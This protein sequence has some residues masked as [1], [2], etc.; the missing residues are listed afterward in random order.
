WHLHILWPEARLSKE[1]F[2]LLL[3]SLLDGGLLGSGLGDVSPSIARV[4][5]AGSGGE[6]SGV[7]GGCFGGQASP[8]ALTKDMPNGSGRNGGHGGWW[9]TAEVVKMMAKEL[10]RRR[11]IRS[12]SA[13]QPNRAKTFQGLNKIIYAVP[14][15]ANTDQPAL[16]L[17]RPKPPNLVIRI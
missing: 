16:L 12:S 17:V 4:N 7:G 14:S 2:L 15:P 6:G 5:N 1:G 13:G 9:H 10:R 3:D 11:L 8:A